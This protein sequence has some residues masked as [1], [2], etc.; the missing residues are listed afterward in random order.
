MR[1]M[2]VIMLMLMT[3]PFVIKTI[4]VNKLKM[5]VITLEQLEIL[6]ERLQ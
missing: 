2:L 3:S 6:K 4:S 5:P 1:F